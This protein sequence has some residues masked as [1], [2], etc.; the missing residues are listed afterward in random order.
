M[1]LTCFFLYD[2]EQKISH[3]D[4]RL[5]FLLSFDFWL[6]YQCVDFKLDLI[7]LLVI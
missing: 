2:F 4:L 6:V 1:D 5:L 3:F 7:K